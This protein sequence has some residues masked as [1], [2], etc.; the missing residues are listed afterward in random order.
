MYA[1]C[2][3]GTNKYSKE[4]IKIMN[5]FIGGEIL[6]PETKQPFIENWLDPIFVFESKISWEKWII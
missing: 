1:D 5:D 4:E 6:D 2:G 3:G